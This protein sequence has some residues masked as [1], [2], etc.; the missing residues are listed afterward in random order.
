[1][2]KHNILTIIIFIC[3]STREGTASEFYRCLD[4]DGTAH[5]FRE[6]VCQLLPD[7]TVLPQAEHPAK[8][9][10]PAKPSTA[11]PVLQEKRA[12]VGPWTVTQLIV[13]SDRSN[14]FNTE[15]QAIIN[16]RRVGVG[17]WVKGGQVREITRTFVVITHAGGQTKV[18]FNRETSID[19]IP[20]MPWKISS[21]KLSTDLPQLLQRLLLGEEV[22]IVH[23]GKPL[24]H[25]HPVSSTPGTTKSASPNNQMVEKGGDRFDFPQKSRR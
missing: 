22:V 21:E 17:A 7:P 2:K 1:M 12:R 25:L 15:K 14:N 23:E 19:L 11:T 5:F 10:N 18:P 13:P 6:R 3:F 8:P 24:A 4:K 16:N 9:S 20:I